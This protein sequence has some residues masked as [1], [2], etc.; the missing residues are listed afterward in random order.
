SD[1]YSLGC[2]L[3]YMLAG[4]PPFPDGTALQKLLRHN[5]DEPP[6][7]RQFRPELSPRV[8]A[9][10]SKLLAKKPSQRQQTASELIAD[11]L[12]VGEQLGLTQLPEMGGPVVI[13]APQANHWVAKAWQTA[14]A[15]ALLMASIVV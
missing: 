6:D 15:F 1:L 10:V 3:F 12:H 14:A 4:Q 9:I 13:T 8:T 11:I 2:T 5:T 7:L